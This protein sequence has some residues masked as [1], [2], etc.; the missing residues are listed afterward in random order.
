MSKAHGKELHVDITLKH[1]V[2][3][4]IL[5]VTMPTNVQLCDKVQNLEQLVTDVASKLE[6]LCNNDGTI[7]MLTVSVSNLSKTLH[8]FIASQETSKVEIK[9]EISSLRG[10]IINNLVDENKSMALK[11]ESLNEKVLK[12]EREANLNAQRSRENN[13]EI[14]G[15]NDSIEDS[16]LEDTCISIFKK[17]D[18][19][20]SSSD[21]EGCHRLP[22]RKGSTN[23]PTI[24]K[25]VNRKKA[26]ELVR[27]KRNLKGLSL[28]DLNISSEVYF[29][30]NL[31]PAFR[32]LDYFCRRLFVDKKIAGYFTSHTSVKIKI[33]NSYHKITHVED[34]RELFDDSEGTMFVSRL[35]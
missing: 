7:A 4:I 27:A 1:Q 5:V 28:A 23:K 6:T 10:T 25:F 33:D 11:I 34:L 9:D 35:Y 21:I 19:D 17:L 32:E 30:L 16:A 29:N 22:S 24:L 31:S 20:C 3:Y 2:K 13:L 12:L 8:D 18:I 14:H 26:E 15:I